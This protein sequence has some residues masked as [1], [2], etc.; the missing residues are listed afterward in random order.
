[1]AN[2]I[3]MKQLKDKRKSVNVR[4]NITNY[5]D[6]LFHQEYSGI[7]EPLPNHLNAR[8]MFYLSCVYKVMD[9]RD[10]DSIEELIDYEHYIKLSSNQVDKLIILSIALSPDRLRNK[11]FFEDEEKCRELLNEFYHKDDFGKEMNV[12]EYVQIGQEKITVLRIMCFK[13]QF[14]T[15]NYRIPLQFYK[16]RVRQIAESIDRNCVNINNNNATT[17]FCSIL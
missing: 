11:C 13:Q 5:P 4:S 6:W 14:V 7:F 1:M 10:A 15:D 3:E 2:M 8:L 12:P 17:C 9:I 16:N